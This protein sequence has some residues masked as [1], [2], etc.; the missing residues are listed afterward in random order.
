MSDLLRLLQTHWGYK[1]F[2]PLQED[3][4]NNIIQKK[5]TLA[6]LPTGG[7]KSLCYQ[8]PALAMEGFCLVVSPLIALMQDQVVRLKHLGIDAA[9]LQAGM[10]YKDVE[11]TL[12][13]MLNG[14][15]KLLYV[16]PERLQSKLFREYLP[17]FDLSMIAVDEAHCVSQ[18]G[19]DFRTDYLK[20]AG[21]RADF[22]QV[23]ILALTATATKEVQDDI[24]KQ[25][26]LR[27]PVTY[28]ESFKRTNI[29]YDIRYTDN[30]PGD[31]LKALETHGGS[32]IIYCRSR[33]QTETLAKTLGNLGVPTL[34]YHAGMARDKREAAQKA[35]MNDEVKTMAA[36]TAFGMGID[37]PDVRLV[38]HYD[39][40]EDPESY[41]QEAGR[42]GRDGKEAKALALY[43]VNDLERLEQSTELNFP[44]EAYL[45][46]VYQSV[47]EY[48]QIPI[49]VEPEQYYAFD[50]TAFCK[51]FNLQALPASNAIR[52][53]EREGLWTLTDAVYNPASV[54]F[55]VDR[56]VLEDLYKSHPELEMICV[57]LLRMY[58]SVFYYPTPIRL[59]VVA[60]QARMNQ[61]MAQELLLRLHQMEVIEYQLPKEGPQLYFHHLR[62]DSNHLLIDL[63]RIHTLRKRHEAR[64]RAMMGLLT[65]TKEC[66]ERYILSYFGE[67]TKVNCGH[68]DR[69]DV[70]DGGSTGNQIVTNLRTIMADSK[71]RTINQVLSGFT[72][73]TRKQALNHL[74]LMLDEGEVQRTEEGLIY[75]KRHQTK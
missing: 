38:I 23:P 30:K 8:L 27:K 4:I 50:L 68:C 71:P 66:R 3:I 7:G 74:R 49:G 45:R 16:S 67:V 32:S 43:H 40:P 46:K 14:P 41:Y 59:A 36:T 48:L 6:L 75:M 15:Y 44:P 55:L 24:S 29:H 54:R 37:K 11:M 58:G 1:T 35:W 31:T 13:N 65:E 5:D 26:E 42:A 9:F 47:C 69:C 20:I 62:V 18:W 56:H 21:V 72:N 10:H 52:L 51:R 70:R 12:R 28:K 2:R 22:P 60:K 34:A 19:H 61:G 64:T 63:T 57:S 33:K 25:L 53:L 17:E 39:A 73:D